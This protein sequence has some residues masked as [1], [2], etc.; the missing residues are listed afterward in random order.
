MKIF[1]LLLF[2]FAILPTT[3][4]QA[5]NSRTVK[6]YLSDTNNNPG[7]EDCGKVRAVNRTIPKTK[8]VAKTA[9]EELF[10]GATKAEKAKGLT[11]IFSQKT[12]SI[13]KSVNIKNGAAYVNLKNWVIQ[14]LGTATTS[15]GAFTFV[16]PIEKTLM[17]FPSVKKVFFAIE[18][19]P[20]DYYE[21]MQVGECPDE[22]V[23]CSGKDF[24]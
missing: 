5:K 24:K 17:Q 8:T 9:L 12:S 14:N 22:L 10:K 19:S 13:L 7:F 3:F 21:W 4:G 2:A 18:G 16:T 1:I 20:K 23:N 15:C 11:S 6:I